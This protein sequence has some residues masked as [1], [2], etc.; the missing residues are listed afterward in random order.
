MPLIQVSYPDL[1][2]NE[3]AKVDVKF[4]ACYGGVQSAGT[5]SF[6]IYGDI[7]F[8]SQFVVFNGKDNTIAMAPH[9]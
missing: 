9:S 2:L 8:K 4:A 5:S 7:L 6:Q 1:L 3:Y